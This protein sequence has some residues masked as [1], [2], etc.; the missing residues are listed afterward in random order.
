MRRRSAVEGGERIDSH[1]DSVRLGANRVDFANRSGVLERDVDVDEE[2]SRAEVKPPRE[3]VLRMKTVEHLIGGAH[4]SRVRH[5]FDHV[6]HLQLLL[7]IL[8][9]EQT[10]NFFG[11]QRLSSAS[12]FRHF[13]GDPK[14]SAVDE[15][16]VRWLVAQKEAVFVEAKA[17]GTAH[18]VPVRAREF[19]AKDVA[20]EGE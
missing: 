14:R 3:Q 1:Q 16:N 18:R 8:R 17:D 19:G 2:T 4:L 20:V 15:P 11:N 10:E 13:V 12:A 9:L 6:R 5:R 7:L